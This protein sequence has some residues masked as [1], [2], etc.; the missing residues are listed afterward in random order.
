MSYFESRYALDFRPAAPAERT[1]IFGKVRVSA[2]TSRLVRVEYSKNGAFTDEATQVVWNRDG[3]QFTAHSAPLSIQKQ[4]NQII[5]ETEHAVFAFRAKNGKLI[6]VKFK[7]SGRTA[8]DPHE[9]NLR[10][11]CRTLDQTI[12]AVKLGEGIISREGLALLDDSASLLVDAGSH[13]TPRKNN[14]TDNYYFAYGHD[15]RSCLR[16]FY[17]LTGQVPF[18]PRWA[19]GNWWS[20]YKAYTQEEYLALMARFDKEQIPITVATIDMDWHWVDLSRFADDQT[21]ITDPRRKKS[22]TRLFQSL[23]WTG[24]SWNTDLFPDWKDFLRTLQ[25]QGRKV[26]VNLHPADG[27]RSF[28]DQYQDMA[29]AM[30]IDPASGEQVR[31]DITD[32]KFVENYFRILHHPLEDA[33]VDFWWIDWQQGE[34]TKVPGLDPLWALNHYHY[35]DSKR[36]LV[37]D[38]GNRPTDE[39]NRPIDSDDGLSE[40]TGRCRSSHTGAGALQALRRPLILSRYAG[41]G[42]HRYP[43]GFSGDN[44]IS[45]ACLRFQPYF[46]AN[47]ANIGYT[48]WSHDI[49]G[50]HQGIK[51][52][53]LYLRW[54]QFGVF[55]PIMRLHSTS[56]EFMGKEPWKYRDDVCARTIELL[57]L[58]HRLVPYIYT[59]NRRSHTDGIAICEPLYYRHP[60]EESAYHHGN[61]YYFGAQ[62][63]CAPVTE[64][65]DEKTNLAEVKLWLPEGRWT[66]LFSGRIYNGNREITV[67][68]GLESIPVF[69]KSGAIIPLSID[70]KTTDWRSPAG[71]ELWIWRGNGSYTLYEDDG[72]S[73]AYQNGEYAETDFVVSEGSDTLKFSIAPKE[74]PACGTS[75]VWLPQKRLYRLSFRDVTDA[76]EISVTVN[77]DVRAFTRVPGDTLMLDIADIHPSDH[78]EAVLKGV[79]TLKNVPTREA[80]IELVSKFQCEVNTKKITW[81]KFVQN[82]VGEIPG[83]E[84]YQAAIREILELA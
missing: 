19:M 64:R 55:N 83:S 10:G 22:I 38:D 8:D 25:A 50:H 58:R 41:P 65:V 30:G 68:R 14:G 44:M 77:G 36:I 33:G 59:E 23:G 71:M 81:D 13:I 76:R 28:E 75:A 74:N 79:S 40:T 82:P 4:G 21:V 45:W 66:D 27:I 43:L 70:G 56:N 39:N 49:G 42:S 16:D 69:A 24:Y 80:L 48:W 12:G 17:A 47:A 2:I 9:G 11:T 62:L 26:T 31:F 6:R 3:A 52:D 29:H 20:R 84:R 61:E 1:A 67:C 37:G 60:E 15:Y 18:I 57:R 63:L 51:D 7:S 53:E 72:E 34:K 5:A 73:M 46:T 54:V 32:P 78:I 35:L